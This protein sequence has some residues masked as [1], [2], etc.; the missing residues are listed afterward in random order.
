[1]K[2]IFHQFGKMIVITHVEFLKNI[3]GYINAFEFSLIVD[4]IVEKIGPFLDYFVAFGFVL[5]VLLDNNMTCV[6]DWFLGDL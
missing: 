3:I 2:G 6:H 1:M 4:L 5:F